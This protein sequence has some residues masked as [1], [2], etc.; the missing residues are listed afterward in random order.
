MNLHTVRFTTDPADVTRTETA[1]R[2]LF[3]A[4]HHYNPAG[5]DYLATR[6]IDSTDFQLIA[7][8]ADNA[9]P[10]LHIN[11]AQDFRN[12]L[13]RI[14]GHPPTPAALTTLGIYGGF[15]HTGARR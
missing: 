4:I 13:G 3:G 2:E 12:T 1:I 6:V 10:L 11:E 15:T 8:F 9:N 7:R 14:L 5:L